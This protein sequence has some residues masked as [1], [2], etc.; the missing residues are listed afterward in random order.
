MFRI[1]D[2]ISIRSRSLV[3]VIMRFGSAVFPQLWRRAECSRLFSTR[4]SAI[5]VPYTQST[6][7]AE[8]IDAVSQVIASDRLIMGPKVTEF[9]SMLARFCGRKFA[10]AVSSGTSALQAVLHLRGVSSEWTVFVPAYTWVATYNVAVATGARVILVDVR[11]DSYCMSMRAL[12]RAIEDERKLFPNRRLCVMPVHMFGYRCGAEVDEITLDAL[13]KQHNVTVIGDACCAFASV[14]NGVTCGNWTPIECTSFHPRKL[15]TTGE[16]GA[17]FTDS[18]E[19]MLR[20][21]RLRDHGAFRDA[22]Q[23]KQTTQGGTLVPQFPEAGFNY[24]MTEMQG[25]IGVEQMKKIDWITS[26]RKSIARRYDEE[27]QASKELSS[28]LQVPLA[29]TGL[30]DDRVLTAYPVKMNFAS[31]ASVVESFLSQDIQSTERY[32][33]MKRLRH[34]IIHHCAQ[35]RVALRPPMICLPDIA[36][37]VRDQVRLGILAS[38]DQV[39]LRFPGA[40]V[41]LDMTFALPSFPQLSADQQSRVLEV[42][43]EFAA[44]HVTE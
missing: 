16:G 27:I 33:R 32:A 21:K 20:L 35:V 9:E 44:A 40:R 25:A 13:S 8:E 5:E 26:R 3:I 38:E 11:P 29:R 30:L 10:V 15:L 23:R 12:E 42:L 24:R 6:V 14:E 4:I 34:E 7:G 39:D 36:F 19:E 41:C 1:A 17:V 22:E 18:E 43:H 2:P 28:L 31:P 37:I